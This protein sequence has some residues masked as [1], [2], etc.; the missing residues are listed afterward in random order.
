MVIMASRDTFGGFTF[1]VFSPKSYS[2]GCS[3]YD[4]PIFDRIFN[5]FLLFKTIHLYME[6][7]GNN[8]FFDL[9]F[10]FFIY[11]FFALFLTC[12]SSYKKQPI[13]HRMFNYFF[14]F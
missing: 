6:L 4:Q 8:M 3:C 10:V 13:F 14:P 7:Y 1:A 9:F 12:L 5:A 2:N 11:L